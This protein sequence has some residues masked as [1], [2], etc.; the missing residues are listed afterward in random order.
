RK[1]QLDQMACDV[2]RQLAAD[3][4]NRNAAVGQIGD[5]TRNARHLF[6]VGHLELGVESRDKRATAEDAE[7]AEHDRP[8]HP[9][10][11][12]HSDHSLAPQLLQN[13]ASASRGVPHCEQK[14]AACDSV[15]ASPSRLARS[16]STCARYPPPA[17]SSRIRRPARVRRRPDIS[18]KSLS[19]SFPIALSNSSSLIDRSTSSFSRSSA[20]RV[21]WPI[22]A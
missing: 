6:R 10:L 3:Q 2:V 9:A 4:T 21:R 7:D 19:D 18:W 12:A 22:I 1:V 15:D 11:P 5:R 17:S 20:T 16:L 8:G 14:C 13:R